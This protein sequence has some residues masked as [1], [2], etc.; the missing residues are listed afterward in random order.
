MLTAS[1]RTFMVAAIAAGA[2]GLADAQSDTEALAKAA[3]N[4]VANMI[5]VPIQNN[6]NFHVGPLDGTQNLLNIQPVVPLSLNADW[7]LITRTIIPIVT[8]PGFAPDQSS[9][10]GL[11]DIQVS[12][13]LSPKV[14]SEWV[15]GAGL[16]TQLP[17]HTNR[18]L[19]NDRVGL[20]PAVVVFR[21]EEGSPWVYGALIN[22]LWSI[23]SSGDRRIN[24]MLLQPVLNYNFPKGLYLTSVPLI[25]ADWE[26]PHRQRWTVPLGGG[27]G[28][29]FHVGEQPLNGQ[30]ST[31]YNVVRPDA[32]PTWQLRLQLQ[33]LFPK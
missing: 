24:Q 31:Y 3:Q 23:T 16:L 30:I 14:V 15:W 7:Y 20:G 33:L 22:N 21:F 12:A 10:T 6:T 19:G 1:F 13:F 26:V 8:Q 2:S 27:V 18:R 28:K 17:T 29:I 9:V 5:S 32:G 25:T 4:P 11:G